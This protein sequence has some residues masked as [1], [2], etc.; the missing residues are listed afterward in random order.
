[1]K[2]R[3]LSGKES[4]RRTQDWPLWI[5]EIARYEGGAFEPHHKRP[6]PGFDRTRYLR[7]REMAYFQH[8]G[9][10]E[11]SLTL[12][13]DASFKRENK[14]NVGPYCSSRQIR[15]IPVILARSATCK[16]S[17]L[18]AIGIGFK[19]ANHEQH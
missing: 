2:E 5:L 1:M 3:T 19:R 11:N 13:R 7:K 9:P 15:G 12:R 8:H 18:N 4:K 10:G 16:Y 6:N 14:D 17:N